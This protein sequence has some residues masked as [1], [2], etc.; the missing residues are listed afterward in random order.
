M[1]QRRYRPAA[2]PNGTTPRT[3]CAGNIRAKLEA[4]LADHMR[5]LAGSGV[6]VTVETLSRETGMSDAL[7]ARLAPGAA[8]R[9]RRA[10][11]RQVQ[12]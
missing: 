7:I 8:A 12:A 3:S 11:I 9:A 4:K 10:S 1:I 5:L 6:L 2:S